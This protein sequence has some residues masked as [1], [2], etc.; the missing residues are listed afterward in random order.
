[1]KKKLSVKMPKITVVRGKLVEITDPAEIAE[2]DRRFRAAI[3]AIEGED[4]PKR[5]PRTRQAK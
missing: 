3:R 1:M 2:L 4:V 5:K